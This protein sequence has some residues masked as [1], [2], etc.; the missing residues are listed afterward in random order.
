[1]NEFVS[2]SELTQSGKDKINSKDI[3]DRFLFSL[4]DSS[5]V[6]NSRKN[7]YS[8]VILLFIYGRY[9]I[10]ILEATPMVPNLL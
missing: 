7:V 6:T 5:V 8:K 9:M 3:T 2:I 1:M 10:P 4:F